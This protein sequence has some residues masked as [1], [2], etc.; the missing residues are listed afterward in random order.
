MTSGISNEIHQQIEA[1]DAWYNTIDINGM[2]TLGKGGSLLYDYKVL[3]CFL[4]TD[5]SEERIIDIRYN[6][7]SVGVKFAKKRPRGAG[8]EALACFY[9]QAV[10]VTKQFDLAVVLKNKV[11]YDNEELCKVDMPFRSSSDYVVNELNYPIGEIFLTASE[12]TS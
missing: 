10:W 4:P 11:I 7:S 12:A 2:T 6:A 3:K 5:L 8:Y 9:H 1:L